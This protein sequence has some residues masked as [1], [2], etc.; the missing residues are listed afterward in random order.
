MMMKLCEVSREGDFSV[1]GDP[2]VLYSVMMA[3]RMAI[4]G[5]AGITT[6]VA[7]QTTLRYCC[8]RR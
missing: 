6:M 4:V 8:V 3:I 2:R 5:W 7:T 1:T